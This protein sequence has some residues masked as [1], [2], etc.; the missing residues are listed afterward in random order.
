M[1]VMSIDQ[2]EGRSLWVVLCHDMLC[3][4]RRSCDH[5]PHRFAWQ[6]AVSMIFGEQPCMFGWMAQN[7]VRD[8]NTLLPSSRA[9]GGPV[10]DDTTVEMKNV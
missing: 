7:V 8:D 2:C 1:C 6:A 10:T 4:C 3:G 5:F 9:T